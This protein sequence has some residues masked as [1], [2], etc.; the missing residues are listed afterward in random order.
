MIKSCSLIDNFVV[1]KKNLTFLKCKKEYQICFDE[2]EFFKT[3]DKKVAYAKFKKLK[4]LFYTFKDEIFN[5]TFED[6]C[7]LT[8]KQIKEIA[9]ERSIDYKPFEENLCF[10]KYY[11]KGFEKGAIWARDNCYKQL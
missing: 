5:S 6:D 10:K 8:N 9:F 4:L 11:E 1:G 7:I 3:T 2:K